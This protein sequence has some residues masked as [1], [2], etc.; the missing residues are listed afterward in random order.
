MSAE[1]KLKPLPVSPSK[2]IAR[3]ILQ[4]MGIPLNNAMNII[5]ENIVSVE[6]KTLEEAKK[7][8]KIHGRTWEKIWREEIGEEFLNRLGYEIPK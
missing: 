8:R 3:D 7:L 6:N 5:Y 1:I 2:W 4:K